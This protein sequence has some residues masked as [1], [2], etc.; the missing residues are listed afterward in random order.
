VVI[1]TRG[2]AEAFA[3][4]LLTG[5]SEEPELA[6]LVR[7]ARAIP[8]VPVALHPATRSAI[9]E[10]VLAGAAGQAARAPAG[11][12]AR[13]SAGQA[14]RASTGQAAR[15]STGDA[16]RA[17]IAPRRSP[18][19]EPDG[20]WLRHS[21]GR[22]AAGFA[23]VALIVSGLAAGATRSLPGEPLYRL[24]Q[25]AEAVQLRMATGPLAKGKRE[26]EFI[27]TR[28]V[29]LDRLR[30][31][32][33]RVPVLV[34]LGELRT[35]VLAAGRYLGTY[36]SRT[37]RTTGRRLLAGNAARAEATLAS[38]LPHLPQG[39]RRQVLS[40]IA[41]FRAATA[42]LIGPSGCPGSSRAVLP[43]SR[44]GRLP[45]PATPGGRS[46][47][48]TTPLPTTTTLPTPGSGSAPVPLPS[49]STQPSPF[50]QPS[51]SPSTQPLP[52]PSTSTSGQLP[53]PV[54][55]LSNGSLPNPTGGLLED[56]QIPLPG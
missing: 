9:R 2:R 36:D 50:T 3:T 17:P 34:E 44:P 45:S 49:P 18:R 23:A 19:F 53:I 30:S 32:T 48:A 21:G 31:S 27:D 41:A 37:R 1:T 38:L 24:Q 33:T 5:T 25:A 47:S 46:G 16:A 54:P 14:A 43:C 55:T 52:L 42:R 10:R 39:A 22:L 8:A 28:L 13:A 11:Q 15:A 26:L 51:T 12:A 40:T 7:L 4:A 6:A 35:E 20:R 29:Q 56:P